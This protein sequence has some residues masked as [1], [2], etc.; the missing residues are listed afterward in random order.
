MVSALFALAAFSTLG[1]VYSQNAMHQ[2]NIESAHRAGVMGSQFKQ[3]LRALIVNDGAGIATGTFTGVGWLKDSGS[4][5]G[6]TGSSRYLPCEFPN[7]LPLNLAY[8]TVVTSVGGVVTATVT[9]GVPSLGGNTAPTLAGEVV[10]AI[11]GTALDYSTPATQTY[12]AAS[13]DVTT[14]AITMIVTNAPENLEFLKR[15]GSVLPTAD[16]D[17]NN[18]SIRNVDD[19]ELNGT[20]TAQ[21]GVITGIQIDGSFDARLTRAVYDVRINRSGDFVNKP[22]CP[23]GST[24]QIFVAAASA[25]TGEAMLVTNSSGAPVAGDVKR[26]RTVADSYPTRW[27]VWLELF[28]SSSWVRMAAAEGDLRSTIKCT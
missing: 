19:V 22:I 24:A 11:N 8:Q 23:S 18:F 20:L 9:F 16:F 13:N 6:A 10:A 14:G 21:D 2:A 15:D 1:F 25:P 28:I 26:F 12:Y 17:W 7:F 4:C 3:A 5:A 27:Q